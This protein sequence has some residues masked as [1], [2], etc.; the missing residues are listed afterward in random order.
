MFLLTIGAAPTAR[1]RSNR[2]C[3]SHVSIPSHDVEVSS[4]QRTDLSENQSTA[5]SPGQSRWALRDGLDQGRLRRRRVARALAE[6]LAL[7]LRGCEIL[8]SIACSESR[9]RQFG[10][11]GLQPRPLPSRRHDSP[12][13]TTEAIRHLARLDVTVP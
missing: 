3:P 13:G 10:I 7:Q 6:D 8:R 2:G 1:G 11:V 12:P 9:R 4:F 5:S